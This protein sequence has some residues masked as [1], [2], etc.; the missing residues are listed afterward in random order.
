VRI[1]KV[2]SANQAGCRGVVRL[3]RKE[4]DHFG[5]QHLTFDQQEDHEDQDDKPLRNPRC[6]VGHP[7]TQF[8]DQECTVGVTQSIDRAGFW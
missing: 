5:R 8:L 4:T 3:T 7:V 6:E 1:L 2:I